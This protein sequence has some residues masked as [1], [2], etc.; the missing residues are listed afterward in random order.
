MDF[1]RSRRF[2]LSSTLFRKR[3]LQSSKKKGSV[4]EVT[5]NGLEDGYPKVGKDFVKWYHFFECIPGQ[6]LEREDSQG[7]LVD[8][9]H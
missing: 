3:S 5:K 1:C 6:Q 4:W 7:V 2:R 9:T 8:K